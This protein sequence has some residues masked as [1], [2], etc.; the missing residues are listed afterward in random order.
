MD[1]LWGFRFLSISYS[2]PI[3]LA[4]VLQ[5]RLRSTHH[6]EDLVQEHKDGGRAQDGR[7]RKGLGLMWPTL[8]RI[9][10]PQNQLG[11]GQY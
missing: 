6:P 3:A 9:H 7:G 1:G 4:Q 11:M 5:L 10:L 8:I 2:L